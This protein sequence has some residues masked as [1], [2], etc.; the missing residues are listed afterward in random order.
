VVGWVPVVR[1]APFL[2]PSRY[3][4]FSPVRREFDIQVVYMIG[5]DLG[6]AVFVKEVV[7]YG[8]I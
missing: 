7:M 4:R 5:F 2:P 1:A 8:G 3:S 6:S